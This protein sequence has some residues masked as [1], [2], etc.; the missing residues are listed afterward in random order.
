MQRAGGPDVVR[1]W[2]CTSDGVSDMDDCIVSACDSSVVSGY[3][4]TEVR[5]LPLYSSRYQ[6]KPT[7][8]KST[9]TTLMTTGTPM[10]TSTTGTAATTNSNPTTTRG[11]LNNNDNHFWSTKSGISH[12]LRVGIGVGVGLVLPIV[13]LFSCCV[14]LS[15]RE[16]RLKRENPE[17]PTPLRVFR[18]PPV[19]A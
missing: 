8:A 6:A 13:L 2:V 18:V 10:T 15:H 7:V 12:G 4:M 11:N 9:Q 19:Y 17:R 14:F 16:Q 3:C 5:D 1:D